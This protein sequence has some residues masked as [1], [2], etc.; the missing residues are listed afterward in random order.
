MAEL[1]AQ[2]GERRLERRRGARGKLRER[3]AGRQKEK[4]LE[5]VPDHD[6][7]R[8]LLRGEAGRLLHV[9][10]ERG[11]L[12]RVFRDVL[13]RAGPLE[14]NADDRVSRSDP[15]RAPGPAEERQVPRRKLEIGDRR[16]CR[17]DAEAFEPL[18]GLGEIALALRRGGDGGSE[19]YRQRQNPGDER[20]HVAG[21]YPPSGAA[22]CRW[23]T[24]RAYN[25]R[26]I[27]GPA[28]GHSA[29]QFRSRGST[30]R[31]WDGRG[32]P[33]AGPA[34]GPRGRDQGASPGLRS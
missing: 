23:R 11:E 9:E 26:A 13:E 21:L 30:W 7:L 29:W 14:E 16:R 19:R 12:D 24:S 20:V 18:D 25:L 5:V 33:R 27:N 8:R 10:E 6:A 34:S 4:P 28:T 31:R 32:L 2:L 17:V 15:A 22:G 3:P 1:L